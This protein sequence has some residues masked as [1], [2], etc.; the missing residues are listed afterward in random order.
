MLFSD[1]AS[2]K[3]PQGGAIDETPPELVSVSPPS[4]TVNFSTRK[5]EIEFSEYMDEASFSNNI[6]I[7]PKLDLP[8]QF[9]FK[10]KKI[11]LT[12]PDS[13]KNN[14]TYIIYLNRNIKDEHKIALANAVQ[15]AY[16]TGSAISGNSIYGKVYGN[17]PGAVHLW[18]INEVNNDSLFA[19]VPNYV[20]DVS[21]SGSYS[22][23]YLPAGNYQILAVEKRGAGLPLVPTQIQYGKHWKNILTL[24]E[25]D[26][27]KNINFRLWKESDSLKIIQG[28]W[29]NSDLGWITFNNDLPIE[30]EA[31]LQ[32][33]DSSGTAIDTFQYYLDPLNHRKL[34]IKTNEL[35]EQNELKIY[36]N[37]LK[38]QNEVL[39]D[40]A[41]ITIKIPTKT[42]TSN[43]QMLEP[44]GGYG[45][46]SGSIANAEKNLAIELIDVKNSRLSQTTLVNSAT[47]FEFKT[48]PAGNYS[49]LIFKDDDKNMKY[50]FGKVYSDAPSEWFYFYPDS[51]EVRANWDTEIIPIILPEKN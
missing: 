18:K 22:F 19:T 4:G 20:T 23:N 41:E 47:E 34:I 51:F 36:V 25:D 24:G 28:E 43:L 40:S 30:I 8:F 33:Q 16:S 5:I 31:D 10:G 32:V 42:D 21:E 38:N 48:V 46:I 49:L 9:K 44:S 6:K 50:T 37:S 13:L 3:A 7:Y 26:T 2:I 29:S 45:S 14:Q 11:I 27:F 12:L 1:C 17:D 39:L 15:I 35:P